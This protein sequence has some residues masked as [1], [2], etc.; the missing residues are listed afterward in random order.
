[1][2]IV[3]ASDELRRNP[4]LSSRTLGGYSCGARPLGSLGEVAL[5]FGNG[6]QPSAPLGLDGCDHG[7][8]AA[9]ER[10]Q[11]DS[12]GLGS[13]FAGVREPV[14]SVGELEIVDGLRLGRAGVTMLRS[15]STSLPT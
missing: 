7:H 5:E 14:D 4:P 6:D 3:D 11:A 2:L 9:V 13:L 15:G 1:M 10:R 12:E 8:D